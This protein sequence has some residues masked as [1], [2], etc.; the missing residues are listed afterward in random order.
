M[1][2]LIQNLKSKRVYAFHMFLRMY[3]NNSHKT[4]NIQSYVRTSKLHY[5]KNNTIKVRTDNPLHSNTDH[6]PL[7][8]VDSV[9][10]VSNSVLYLAQTA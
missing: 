6:F 2:T 9:Q 1:L 4:F 8:H 3:I 5:K 7:D 10:T